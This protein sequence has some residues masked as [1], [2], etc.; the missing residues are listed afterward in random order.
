MKLINVRSVCGAGAQ[1]QRQTRKQRSIIRIRNKKIKNKQ[2]F[3]K[4]NKKNRKLEKKK[5]KKKENSKNKKIF[6]E[7]NIFY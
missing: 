6:P 4:K 2:K 5:L 1:G 7:I 3:N